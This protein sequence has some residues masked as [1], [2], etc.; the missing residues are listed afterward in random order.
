MPKMH[1]DFPAQ[2][3]SGTTL[4]MKQKL[5]AIGY[6][7]GS[8]GEYS[9]ALRNLLGEGIRRYVDGLDERRRAEYESILSNIKAREVL[10]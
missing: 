7:M 5:T 2:L 10:S 3:S 1:K 4:E 8:G 9:A 6:M